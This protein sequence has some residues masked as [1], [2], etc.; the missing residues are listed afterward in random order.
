MSKTTK[1]PPIKATVEINEGADQDKP[2]GAILS[3]SEAL[4]FLGVGETTL[5]ALIDQKRITEGAEG[6]SLDNL[7]KL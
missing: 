1:L 7:R 6:F 5:D 4:K 3:R 2:V